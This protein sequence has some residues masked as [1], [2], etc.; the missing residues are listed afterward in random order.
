MSQPVRASLLEPAHQD[1]KGFERLI[2]DSDLVSINYLERGARIAKAVCRLRVPDPGG[3]WFGTGF[4]VGPRLLL[5]NHHVIGSMQEA[6]QAE[7]EFDYDHDVDGVRKQPAAFNLSP[8]E[9]FYTD[10]KLDFSLISVVPNSS[11]GV[12]LDRYGFLPMIPLSG[13][14]LH[15]EWVTIIQ[16][17]EGLPKQIAL[18]K[19][20]LQE[21]EDKRLQDVAQDFIHY[22]VDTQPGSSG[23]PVLTDQWQVVALHHRAI[24]SPDSQKK[25][26]LGQ[27]AIDDPD[28]KW[29]A[30]QGVRISAIFRALQK[31]RFSDR[32][33]AAALDRLSQGIGFSGLPYISSSDDGSAQFEAQRKPKPESYWTKQSADGTL[34]YDPKFLPEK[35]DLK[36]VLAPVSG[37]LAKLEKGSGHLLDYL[38]FS[39]AIDAP[40]KFATM[41]A[42]NINGSSLRHPGDRS[43]SWRRDIRMNDVFQPGDNFYVKKLGNDPVAFSRGHL[44]RR[45]D[46]CWGTQDEAAEAEMQTFHFSNAAPQV[47]RYNNV[48]WGDLED[49]VLDRTQ[50]KE[51]KVS[52]FTGP[53]FRDDDPEYGAAREG[54]PWQIPVSF[55]KIAVIE[56]PGNTIACAAFIVG[57]IEYLKALYESR[58]FT[59]LNPYSAKE[60]KTRSLQVTVQTVMNETG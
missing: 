29:V 31:R 45:F 38:H 52:V 16:H 2:G 32:M 27:I 3:E 8:H 20:Q 37:R 7:A 55:W 24:L 9:V 5:T 56:K 10:P 13:K 60:I 15:G 39:I 21:I 14:G 12:P 35:I 23:A 19:S 17:P 50:T 42:V 1:P 48:E 53:I 41:A 49:Y 46:P 25:I 26:E 4:L 54:G 40:R 6:A 47:Q 22:T 44:V 33:A 34:G 58:V 51:R 36:D 59:G 57:Q 28:V 18:R 30:N 11:G 43:D